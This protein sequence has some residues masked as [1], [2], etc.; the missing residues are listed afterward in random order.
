MSEHLHRA[1]QAKVEGAAALL[2]EPG[3]T[4]G[5]VR[6]ELLVVARDDLEQDINYSVQLALLSH[7]AVLGDGWEE[8]V[9]LSRGLTACLAPAGP[10]SDC[11]CCLCSS[12]R[13]VRHADGDKSTNDSIREGMGRTP[14]NLMELSYNSAEFHGVH[15]CKFYQT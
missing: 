12:R 8:G 2:H 6:K 15:L 7:R 11:D 14:W 1:P 3:L 5:D 4:D 10:L 13:V 9:L